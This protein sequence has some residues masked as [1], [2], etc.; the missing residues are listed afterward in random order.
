M[1]KVLYPHTGSLVGGSLVSALTVAKEAETA[2]HWNSIFAFPC[3]GPGPARVRQAN[4]P[5]VDYGLHPGL[6][7]WWR[8]N[9]R[10]LRKLLASPVGMFMFL[11]ARKVIRQYAPDL[12]HVNDD[13]SALVWGLAAK[14]AN[15]PAVWHIRQERRSGFADAVRNL[16]MEQRVFL[17]SSA[18]DRVAKRSKKPTHVIP[19]GIDVSAISGPTLDSRV[20]RSRDFRFLFLGNIVSRKRPILA[21]QAVR[22]MR[23]TGLNVS[24]RL[25]GE[26]SDKTTVRQLQQLI[27][28]ESDGW[29]QYLG[30]CD[31]PGTLFQDADALI[32]TSTQNGEALP[33]AA[34]EA[35]AHGLPV[36]ATNC[37]SVADIVE[38]GVTGFVVKEDSPQR[39]AIQGLRLAQDEHL[40][41]RMSSSAREKVSRDYSVGRIALEIREVYES[42][43]R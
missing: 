18:H 36:L 33:R 24:L 4:L 6:V 3:D 31:A 27:A 26:P 21:V 12:I 38:D 40:W 1:L 22:E 8:V 20:G 16:V 19:N 30:Y 15:I 29:C 39:L 34:L 35:H 42:L 14:S 2:R 7:A 13:A 41:S 23:A 17:S 9:R 28:A 32:L 37:G 5:V 10:S 25:A 43:F 11:Q